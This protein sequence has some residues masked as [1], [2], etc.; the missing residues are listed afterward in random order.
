M[1]LYIATTSQVVST[2]LAVELEEAGKIHGAQRP[3]Y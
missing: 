3:V 1:L 2:V